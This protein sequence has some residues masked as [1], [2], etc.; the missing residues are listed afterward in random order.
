[1][2]RA[3]RRKLPSAEPLKAVISPWLLLILFLAAA[4]ICWSLH[5]T[6]AAVILTIF[7]TLI[8]AGVVTAPF[9]RRRHEEKLAKLPPNASCSYARS[10]DFRHTETLVMRAVF[11]ELQ[12]FV[13]FP[14]LASHGLVEDLHLDG[15][16]FSLDIAPVIAQR[17][18]RTLRGSDR[19]P[20]YGRINTVEDLVRFMEA[21]PC[22]E[23]RKT[24]PAME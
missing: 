3:S 5:A 16:D 18:D 7:A 19:N 13:E 6:V 15:E 24:Q 10:F 20:Y 9:A 11:E 23:T 1:M 22:Q 8:A 4:A 17:L 2:I 21:Q 14:I 12:P